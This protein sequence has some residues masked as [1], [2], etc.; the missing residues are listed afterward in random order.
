MIHKTP[1]RFEGASPSQVPLIL[2]YNFKKKF[3]Y[4]KKKKDVY[5]KI[6]IVIQKI[7]VKIYI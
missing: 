3:I 5:K 6:K 7:N 2:I 4:R 1:P